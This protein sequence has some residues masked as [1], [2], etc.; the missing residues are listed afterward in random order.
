[1]RRTSDQ[2]LRSTSMSMARGGGRKSTLVAWVSIV[3]SALAA[4]LTFAGSRTAGAYPDGRNEVALERMLPGRL[5]IAGKNS[6]S[7]P[8]TFYTATP[9]PERVVGYLLLKLDDDTLTFATKLVRSGDG[10]DDTEYSLSATQ[11]Q[12]W[13]PARPDAARLTGSCKRDVVLGNLECQAKLFVGEERH[14]TSII[15]FGGDE[16]RKVAI[17]YPGKLSFDA[18]P[19][20]KKDAELTLV[21]DQNAKMHG[22]LL[23]DTERKTHVFDSAFHIVKRNERHSLAGTTPKG[24]EL[25]A[26]CRGREDGTTV[27]KGALYD[28]TQRKAL[29]IVFYEGE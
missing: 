5:T 20:A 21:R 27:C 23:V 10:N 17:S 16:S 2:P 3:C 29:T 1:M 25:R 13:M 14:D 26:E 28:G 6:R 18:E 4:V 15:L 12:G 19:D 7:V 8:A 22:T 9:D 11:R 24:R